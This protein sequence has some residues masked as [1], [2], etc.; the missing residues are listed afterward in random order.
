MLLPHKRRR[1]RNLR[2]LHLV[3]NLFTILGLCAGLT[4]IRYALDGRWELAV[5]FIVVAGVF[6]GLD[7]RS[8]RLLKLTSKL[9]AELDSLADFLSFGVAPAVIVYLW[10]LR[11][12]Q[13]FGWALAMLFATCCALRLA[14]FNSELEQ[15]D[16]PR[17]TLHFFT[18]IPAPAAAW[19]ALLPMMLS[20][21]NAPDLVRGWWLNAVLLLFV[22]CMMVSRVPT[23]SVK[24]LRVRRDLVLPTLLG[25]GLAIAFAVAEPWLALSL[26]GLAYLAALPFGVIAA[27]RMRLEEEARAAAVEPAAA[28][29]SPA[30]GA[31]DQKPEPTPGRIVSLVEPRQGKQP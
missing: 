16:R 14:R 2:L 26:A 17:W 19:L 15:P 9:G 18:G 21:A 6:D 1:P 7:G 24:R 28:A 29:A 4:G 23:F 25:C 8:A 27:R 31:T 12:V 22:A 5:T 10:S 3:P 13:G 20:F 11:E 30:D